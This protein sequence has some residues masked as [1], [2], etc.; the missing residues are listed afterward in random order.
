VQRK[1]KSASKD[2]LTYPVKVTT[3]QMF[4][5]VNWE[6]TRA[7]LGAGIGSYA[8]FRGSGVSSCITG[9]QG[10]EEWAWIS[11]QSKVSVLVDEG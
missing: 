1:K 10:G 5:A 6:K 8:T 9:K 3:L 2:R 11:G 4:P 7:V